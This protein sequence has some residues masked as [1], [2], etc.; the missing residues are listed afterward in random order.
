[1]KRNYPIENILTSFDNSNQSVLLE[2]EYENE[3]GTGLGPTLEMYSELATEM[4]S[5]L[6]ELL[7]TSDDGYL[8]PVPLNPKYRNSF[9]WL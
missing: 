1:V 2:F 9:S 3:E 5:P 4:K 6:N 7:R 8:F